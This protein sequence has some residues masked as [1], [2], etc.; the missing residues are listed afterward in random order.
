MPRTIHASED[1]VEVVEVEEIDIEATSAQREKF[2]LSQCN[3]KKRRRIEVTRTTSL[4]VQRGRNWSEEDSLLLIEAN[5]WLEQN[6]KGKGP[7]YICR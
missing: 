6:K 3:D 1:I 2:C 4:P 7:V 5:V